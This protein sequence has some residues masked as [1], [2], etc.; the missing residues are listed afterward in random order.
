M[1][2]KAALSLFLF[3]FAVLPALA[4]AQGAGSS[5]ASVSVGVALEYM[6]PRGEFRQSVGTADWQHQGAIA[7]DLIA[8]VTHSGFLSI[9]FEYM[10]GHYDKNCYTCQRG[11]RSTSV[12]PE[13]MFPRGRAR[14]Y[15]MGAWGRLHFGGFTDASGAKADTGVGQWI[16]GGGVRVPLQSNGGW[17]L[18]LGIRSH[19]SGDVSYLPSGVQPE[20]D[21]SV[22]DSVRSPAPFLMYAIGFQYQFKS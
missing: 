9:R 4:F 12:G 14:P 3:L 13:V 8:P 1:S 22:T 2:R 16:Y 19:R 17:S 5:Q 21:G 6:S 10:F 7:F 18:D 20:L 11:F 15:A